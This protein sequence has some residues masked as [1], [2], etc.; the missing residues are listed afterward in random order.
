MKAGKITFMRSIG[1][2]IMM[3][4]TLIV[5]VSIG[6]VTVLSVIQSSGALMDSSYNQLVAIREIKKSQIVRYFQEREG[7]MGVL[8]ET[9]N[10]LRREA[11]SKLEAI[12]EQ[13]KHALIDYID[14]L[15]NQLR[16]LKDDPYTADAIEQ[17]A[18]AFGEGGGRTDT[19]VWRSAAGRYNDRMA[20]I[21]NDNGW[22]DLFLIDRG[23]HIVYTVGRESD[24]GQTL[25]YGPLADSPIGR[26][27]EK[28]VGA[29]TESVVVADFA[30]YAPS[31]GQ[32][33]GFML[34]KVLVGGSLRGYVALQIPLDKINEI[35][36]ERAGM[37]ETGETYLVGQDN[38]MRS[39][40]FLDPE[41]Y[42][43]TA[44]FAKENTVDT[45]AVRESLAGREGQ[46]VIIDYNGNPVL[47]CWD[48]IDLGDGVYWAMM[49]EMDVAE[50]FCPVDENG[51]YYF[52]KYIEKY[53][54]YDLFLMNP[55]G[56]V[57][58]TVTREADYGTNMVNG[59]FSGS[60]LGALTRRVMETQGFG[61]ADF[62]PYAPSNGAPAAFIAQP[63]VNNGK[64]EAVVALQL[65]LEGIN[66]IMME[67]TGMGETGESYL[68]G[69]NKLMRSDSFLDP[70]NHSVLASF[71][72]PETGQVD[73]EAARLALS[74]ETDAKIITDYNGNPVLSAF[75]PV[76]VYETKWAIL[77]E[78]DEAEVR[79]PIN[80]LLVFIIVS[81][82]VMI[83]I[84]IVVAVLFSRTISK[85]ILLV[86]DGANHLA[87]GDIELTGMDWNEIAKINARADELGRIG[88]SFSTLIEYQKEKVAIAQEIAAK[89]LRVEASI[90]SEQDALGKAFTEM[91]N[92]LN[93]MLG[94]VNIAVDQVSTGSDQVSQASQNLSQGATEQASSLEEITSSINEIN[95]QSQGNTK[96]AEEANT[97]AKEAS[98]AANQGSEQMTRL[99]EAMQGITASSDE[100][101]NIVK[102]IDDISFQINLLALNANV[103]AARAGKYGKGFA[104]VAEEVRNLANRSGESVQE[105]SLRVEEAN[106]NI[107]L[108]SDLVEQTSKQ[109]EDIVNGSNRV[110]EFL[111]EITVAS[112][113]QTQ[114]IEQIT[115]ALDQIDQV[116]QS[117]TA[118]AEESA[119][120][121]EELAS[122]AEQLKAMIAQFQLDNRKAGVQE[123]PRLESNRTGRMTSTGRTD[124]GR[125]RSGSREW[126]G[127]SS[128]DNSRETT[129]ITV[130][131]GDADETADPSEVINLDDESFDRF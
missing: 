4:I 103:E 101:N 100:I 60:N 125:D 99:I 93:I 45:K 2:K 7:D 74:G 117:N 77:S 115:E 86:V 97:L 3:I 8:M 43:V 121:A 28:V 91:V 110:A 31:G 41:G 62:L 53:G 35:M 124:D 54:Y 48:R 85:P 25:A 65:P 98:T 19:S 106:K 75:T 33:A 131:A 108:G 119:S 112:R 83:A 32:A 52:A 34:A 128:S 120:S 114:G 96:S 105:T 14:V 29:D 51:V 10:T 58:Y 9:V 116:T 109:L 38:L 49:S 37:G 127:S 64:V 44:S 126:N 59:K 68:I 118:S 82:L 13:K 26:G 94:Q 55:D 61:F 21:M 88:Q 73:T 15:K 130:P 36:L 66:A 104:V 69:P 22:Y 78:I 107:K 5:L 1:G 27:F 57:F 17:L 80:A 18:G 81:A 123:V 72:R 11:F 122:Q 50:A 47:S 46:E 90:S 42:S 6:A 84:S 40:S 39:D 67:R 129:A 71:S 87:V 30:P 70:E 92:S 63:V 89:N 113:E 12:Q 23:G 20:D 102:T 79:A 95:S 56:F 16:V 111:D 24:L 76:D